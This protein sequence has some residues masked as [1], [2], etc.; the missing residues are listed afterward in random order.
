MPAEA[1]QLAV[2]QLRAPL[3]EDRARFVVYNKQATQPAPAEVTCGRH[4]R[5]RRGLSRAPRRAPRVSL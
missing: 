4:F 3:H 1:L 5:L 2:E